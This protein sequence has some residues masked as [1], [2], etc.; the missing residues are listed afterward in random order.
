MNKSVTDGIVFMPP[1]FSAGLDAWSRGDGT[2]GSPSWA[3][4]ADAV[5][6]PFDPDFGTALEVLKSDP[7]L[8]LR[9]FGATP[10]LP[11]CYLRV[12][13]RLKAMAG[14]LPS[15]RV[16]L[17]PNRADGS[18]TPGVPVTGPEVAL[19]GYGQVVE[20]SA[21]IGTGARGGVDLGLGP[22]TVSAHIGLD[23]TGPVGGLVRIESI[24][25]E[26]VTKLFLRDMLDIVD[27]RDFGAAGDGVT[28]DRA[29][30][31]AADAAAQGRRVLV[32]A[33][34]YLVDGNLTVHS[35]IRFHGTIISP[36][37]HRFILMQ[38][39]DLATYIEA[40]GGDE[41]LAF[42][43][44]FQALLNFSGHDSLDLCG[45]RIELTAPIDMAAAVGNQSEFAIRRVI[46][47][48]QF[49]VLESPAWAD[50]VV[51]AVAQYS[52]ASPR[53]LSNVANAA[54]VPVGALVTGHGVG[55]EVYVRATDPAA[56]TIT[57][58]QPLHGAAAQQ[59]Y[60]FRRFKYALDFSGFSILRR[61][62]LSDVDFFLQGHASGV[63]LAPE[64]S[65]MIFRDCTFNRPKDRGIT[66]IGRGCQDIFLDRNNFLSNEMP[67]PSTQRQ[68]IAF[69]LNA[70]DSKIRHNRGV[71]FRHFAV[72]G[73]MMH[74]IL[75]NHFFQGEDQGDGARLAGLILTEPNCLTTINGNYIDNCFIEWNNE[76]D[77]E[78]AFGQELSFGGLT[79]TGNIFTSIGAA[80]FNRWIV[81]APYGPGHFINGLAV[82]SNAFKPVVG[83]ALERVE[84]VDTSRA[85]LDQGRMRNIT[86]EGNAFHQIAARSLNPVPL[87]HDQQTEAST[88]VVECAGWLPFGG[89]ART[90]VAVQPE[91]PLQEAG[92]AT[93]HGQPFALTEQGPEGTR[94][95][96]R[97]PV[98]VRGR[99]RVTVRMDNPL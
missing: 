16:A 74:M 13:V 33:G 51:E 81:V 44:A 48:G 47:N 23:L 25:I 63:M 68:T 15:V 36:P 4:G 86:F 46:R 77:A 30:F 80:A 17:R 75:G 11:G 57:L 12:S 78:P 40:F 61:L 85:E 5:L 6:A 73:G 92:G 41:A 64:G 34:S 7:L 42:R 21:L 37:Q 2:A 65:E 38:G 72:I 19:P 76:H 58:S 89:R 87:L 56:G 62:I 88:W 82:T 97:W 55:R 60:S 28:D 49:N 8:R 26:D 24:R 67:L 90:V 27:V 50:E 3:G 31:L 32:P 20:A 98:A 52:P 18:A 83:P 1:A 91:G 84:G 99:V 39:F 71:R 93:H 66:S 54:Q 10:L 79:I 53:T 95:H 96:L 35:P 70:N 69:N 94:I 43:K 9:H 29:A 45:R 14:A 22:A 59:G